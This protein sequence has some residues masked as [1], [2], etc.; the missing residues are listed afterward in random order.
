VRRCTG[1][2]TRHSVRQEHGGGDAVVM[3]SQYGA[4]TVIVWLTAV[5]SAERGR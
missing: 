2:S 4:K 1:T 5:G 3:S